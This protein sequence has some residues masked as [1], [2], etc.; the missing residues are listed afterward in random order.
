MTID[1]LKERIKIKK[2]RQ[3]FIDNLKKRAN[4][5][6]KTLS[7][8]EAVEYRRDQYGLTCNEMAEIIG[9]HKSKYSEFMN[10]K[11]PLSV[12]TLKKLYYIGVPAKCLLGVEEIP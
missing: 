5:N 9:I 1:K 7:V 10:G 12:K 3:K 4:K 11:K 8:I 2:E 6:V